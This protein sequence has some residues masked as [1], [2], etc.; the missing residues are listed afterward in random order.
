M[1]FFSIFWRTAALNVSSSGLFYFQEFKVLLNRKVD[2]DPCLSFD[3]CA[4]I[5]LNNNQKPFG[6]N[7]DNNGSTQTNTA[8][9]HSD[10]ALVGKTIYSGPKVLTSLLGHLRWAYVI[11]VYENSTGKF[12]IALS[13]QL[14]LHLPFN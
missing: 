7:T 10:R 3:V 6:G 12:D 9:D 5:Q 1:I 8:N 14:H 13:Y 11:V 2:V 4:T